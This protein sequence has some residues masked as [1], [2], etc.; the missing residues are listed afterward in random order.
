MGGKGAL[1]LNHKVN[2]S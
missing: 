2:G 1:S